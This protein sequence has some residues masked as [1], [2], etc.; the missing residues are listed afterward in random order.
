MNSRLA[1][2]DAHPHQPFWWREIQIFI[3]SSQFERTNSRSIFH[4][5]VGA[6]DVHVVD[7]SSSPLNKSKGARLTATSHQQARPS[8]G[9]GAGTSPRD[10][11]DAL[12]SRF[13]QVLCSRFIPLFLERIRARWERQVFLKYIFTGGVGPTCQ[14]PWARGSG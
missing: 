7:R 6:T 1:W 13:W 9:P 11:P 12:P 4:S 8:E 10:G 14:P 3:W 5:R 2:G